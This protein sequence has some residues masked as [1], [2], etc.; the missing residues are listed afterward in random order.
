M[1]EP[2][3]SLKSLKMRLQRGFVRAFGS[4]AAAALLAVAAPAAAQPAATPPPPAP[5][6]AGDKDLGGAQALF[7][8]GRAAMD[9]GDYPTACARFTASLALVTR[10]STLLNLAQCE[11]HEG[12]L[13]NAAKHVSEGINLLP[14]DDERLAISKERAA[15]LARRL[16][17]LTVKLSA[18]PPA[19]AR[20]EIDGVDTSVSKA[21]S[22]VAENPGQHVIVLVN[23][24]QADQRSL[25]DLAEGES[26]TVTLAIQG[27]AVAAPKPVVARSSSKRTLGFVLGGV[28]VAGL[29]GAGITGG[30]LVSRNSA[31]TTACPLKRCNAEGLSLIASTKSLN[32]VNGVA[33][34]VGLAGLA[35]GVVLVVLGRGEGAAT[36]VGPTALPGGGGFQAT[37]TF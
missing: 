2:P 13:V 21:L 12:Q 16:A 35:S 9:R 37:G 28:G 33:W 23:P 24:G 11:T 32:V 25:V 20:L 27:A 15:A 34:G 17:H 14:T 29:I 7:V 1:T 36:A 8:D 22:G 30:I 6:T 3:A 4:A 10:A 31:I 19:A 18:A 26:K 5:A